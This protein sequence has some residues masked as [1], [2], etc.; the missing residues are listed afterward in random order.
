MPAMDV[1]HITTTIFKQAYVFLSLYIF[2]F[3]HCFYMIFFKIYICFQGHCSS[4]SIIC[5]CMLP[6]SL[7]R[8][9][10]WL[11]CQWQMTY[12]HTWKLITNP[13]VSLLI[14]INITIKWKL[15]VWQCFFYLLIVAVLPPLSLPTLT[16]FLSHSNRKMPHVCFLLSL[17]DIY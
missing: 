12:L 16:D 11:C 9:I 17:S 14:F 8:M 13:Q 15:F 10:V 1:L 6:D 3:L 4:F 7:G 2:F 5:I